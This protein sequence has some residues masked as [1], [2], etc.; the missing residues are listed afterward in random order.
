[1]LETMI[2]RPRPSRMYDTRDFLGRAVREHL[3]RRQ[4]FHATDDTRQQSFSSPTAIKHCDI[5]RTENQNICCGGADSRQFS[6][7]YWRVGTTGSVTFARVSGKISVEFAG[8]SIEGLGIGRS[9]ALYR[10][11]WPGTGHI[12]VQLKPFL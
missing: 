12:S 4:S 8:F 2:I 1:M 6:M 9:L 11:I 10:H 3:G 7:I 5:K